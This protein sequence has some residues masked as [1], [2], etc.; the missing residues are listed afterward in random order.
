MPGNTEKNLMNA[1]DEKNPQTGS[2]LS[3]AITSRMATGWPLLFNHLQA[4]TW[5]RSAKGSFSLLQSV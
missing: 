1:W 5:K 4:I 3:A 2:L